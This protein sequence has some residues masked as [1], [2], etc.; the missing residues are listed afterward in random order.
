[1]VPMTG[2]ERKP[3]IDA[4]FLKLLKLKRSEEVRIDEVGVQ[5]VPK[6]VGKFSRSKII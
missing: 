6:F 4:G 3:S 1:M 5:K 2:I